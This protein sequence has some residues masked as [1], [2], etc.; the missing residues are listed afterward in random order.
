MGIRPVNTGVMSGESA[1]AS[2][3]TISETKD[4][5]NIESGKKAMAVGSFC[6]DFEPQQC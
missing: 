2:I 6:V 5:N 3:G 1:T 4:N